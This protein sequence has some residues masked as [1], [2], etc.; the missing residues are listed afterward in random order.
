V[1][2]ITQLP[3]VGGSPSP[4]PFPAPQPAPG[5]PQNPTVCPR[6]THMVVWPLPIWTLLGYGDSGATSGLYDFPPVPFLT[7]RRS[8]RRNRSL[9]RQYTRNNVAALA[10]ARARGVRGAIHHK[11]PLFV[12][13]PDIMANFVFLPNTQHYAWHNQLARQGQTGWMIRDP[14]GTI[15]CVV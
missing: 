9:V 13:G 12:S 1:L 7:R 11:V 10:A 2:P 15:Y 3:R 8:P 14:Y 6:N 4:Y 5:N